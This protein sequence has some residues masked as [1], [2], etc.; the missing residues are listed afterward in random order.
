MWCDAYEPVYIKEN[1][2]AFF[3]TVG[4]RQFVDYTIPKLSKNIEQLSG[5]VT[6]L[7]KEIIKLNERIAEL[8]AENSQLRNGYEELDER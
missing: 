5:V 1:A 8:E 7:T 4:G 6:D 3:E 2:M